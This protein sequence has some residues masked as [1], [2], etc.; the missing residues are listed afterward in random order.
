MMIMIARIQPY[1]SKEHV[2]CLYI[3]MIMSRLNNIHNLL[4]IQGTK[5]RGQLKNNVFFRIARIM[6][7]G[8]PMPEIF[9]PLFRSAFLVNKK[10]LFLQ[11]C[12]CIEL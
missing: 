3:I 6:G 5:G 1:T 11:K 9:G 2:Y 12:Q 10:S 4:T 8:L 7:G